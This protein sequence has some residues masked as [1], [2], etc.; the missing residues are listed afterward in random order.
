LIALGAVELLAPF[1]TAA[2]LVARMFPRTGRGW[3]ALWI[4]LSCAL[5]VGVTA[6]SHLIW[7]LLF[8][9]TWALHWAV[10]APL[11]LGALWLWRTRDGSMPAVESV[12]DA[13]VRTRPVTNA[14]LG[15]I[16]AA[17]AL[18][19]VY[20]TVAALRAKP[21]GEWDAWAVWNP[22]ARIILR[23][24]E[25]WSLVHHPGI[26]HPDYPPLWPLLVARL[27]AAARTESWRVPAYAGFGSAL[28]ALGLVSASIA[29]R[30]GGAAASLAVLV[31]LGLPAMGG[32]PP[33]PL[34]ARQAAHQFAD[35]PVGCFVLA[36]LCCVLLAETEG[37]GRTSALALAGVF[38]GF[39]LWTKS[40]GQLVVLA[41]L[42]ALVA[43]NLWQRGVRSAASA[44]ASVLIGLAPFMIALWVLKAALIQT[45]SPIFE[46]PAAE[47]AGRGL[48]WG[49]HAYLLKVVADLTVS[50]AHW[51]TVVLLAGYAAV[52]G[53]TR[54]RGER[55]AA[56]AMATMILLVAAGYY[57]IYAITPYPLEW[58]V[59]ASIGRLF[60]H[61]WPS[62]VLLVFSASAPWEDA[63]GSA[64]A[65]NS[66]DRSLAS[67][68]ASDVAP[69][70]ALRR[71]GSA[72]S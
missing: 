69:K 39:A 45:G 11:L 35:L 62:L 48:A 56:A 17:A 21:H 46:A 64:A 50:P 2:L 71:A 70:G 16:A 18:A 57:A 13:T 51:P 58:Y 36:C 43:T 5:G 44:L 65:K 4:A 22:K 60:V 31:S 15:A 23:G 47:I 26:V 9:G 49:R 68:D 24:P 32:N 28:L 14:I 30:K 53:P 41:L 63:V 8:P 7:L 33:I 38:A 37:R 40:E 34:L 27:W 66:L 1:A 10:D 3:T 12:E 29:R 67:A 72:G 61:V 6:F 25:H 55:A 52:M 20:V 19:S 54:V 42:A 59:K